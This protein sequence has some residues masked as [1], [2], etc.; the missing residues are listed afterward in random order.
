MRLCRAHFS[1]MMRRMYGLRSCRSVECLVLA[2]APVI[3]RAG[4]FSEERGQLHSA[5][6][7][8][9]PQHV[10]SQLYQRLD[11][12]PLLARRSVLLTISLHILI[13]SNASDF[14]AWVNE[15]AKGWDYETMK[16]SAAFSYALILRLF[17]SFQLF[18]QG[19]K[20]HSSFRLSKPKSR[21]SWYGRSRH[22]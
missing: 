3:G 22:H 9:P 7:C 19:R 6:L 20:I 11:V 2:D 17:L 10:D 21:S 8:L 12:S 16:P 4:D 13:D 1:S 15:G 5:N 14:S 18:S